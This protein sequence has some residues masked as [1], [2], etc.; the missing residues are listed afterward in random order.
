MTIRAAVKNAA[1]RQ[2]V[3]SAERLQVRT[4]AEYL[5]ALVE[6]MATPT[7]RRVLWEL[8]TI[9]RIH[10]SVFSSN[11]TDMAYLAGRQDYG[12]ELLADLLEAD[13]DLYALL[14]QEARA[15]NRKRDRTIEA[16]RTLSA[17][18]QTDGSSRRDGPEPNSAE[19]GPE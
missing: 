17:E 10:G 4:R 3:R 13:E 9:A 11:T 2:Q 18:E 15:R 16:Q 19:Y 1:D 7:G 12:H 8:L 6:V 14:E 5:A